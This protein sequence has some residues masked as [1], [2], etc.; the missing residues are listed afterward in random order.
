MADNVHS[1]ESTWPGPPSE[2]YSVGPVAVPPSPVIRAGVSPP[3]SGPR[4]VAGWPIGIGAPS[5]VLR[6]E[7]ENRGARRAVARGF[8]GRKRSYSV[9]CWCW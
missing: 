9:I 3:P 6:G 7:S 8:G 2:K 1:V 5:L 4:K